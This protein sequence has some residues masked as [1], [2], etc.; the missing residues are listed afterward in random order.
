MRFL[1]K[2]HLPQ[3]LF[4]HMQLVLF[5]KAKFADFLPDTPWNHLQH[6]CSVQPHNSVIQNC[7]TRLGI[8]GNN[9]ESAATERLT[10][11]AQLKIRI[12]QSR[13]PQLLNNSSVY[14]MIKKCQ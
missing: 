1:V 13:R 5:R 7:G 2:M 11:K 4:P 3:D 8:G 10:G 9:V 12:K 6:V 14:K